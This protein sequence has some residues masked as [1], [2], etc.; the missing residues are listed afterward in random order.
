MSVNVNRNNPDPFYRYKMP[1]IVAKVEGK[2]NGIRTVI[3]NM[4]DVAKALA[5]PATYPTKFFGCKLGAQT[6]V[7]FKND[8]YIVNGAHEASKLQDLLDGFIKKYVLCPSCDNPETVLLVKSSI[9]NQTCK[10]CSH[11]GAI[12][13]D[14]GIN[15]Y[16]IKN[17][18]EVNP[19]SQGKSL[20]EGKRGRRSK[21]QQ[22]DSDD[23]NGRSSPPEGD[24][25][26]ID[27]EDDVG[28]DYWDSIAEEP[29]VLKEEL[30]ETLRNLTMN[31]DCELSE[32]E[33]M[34][35]F[36]E[37]V[38]KFRDAGTLGTKHKEL[39]SMA[40]RLEIRAKVPLILVELLCDEN[41]LSQAGKHRLLFRRFTDDNPKAQKYVIGGLEQIIALHK[42]VL[43][44]KVAHILKLFYDNDI[45][46]EK[47]I[48]E[49]AAK[50]SKKYVS[51]EL[52]EEMHQ[53]AEVFV[54]WLREAEEE[55]SESEEEDE[56][57]DDDV[58]I[59]YND[60]VSSTQLTKVQQPPA[61]KP[62]AAE[63]GIDDIDIDAI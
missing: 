45:L 59:E 13:V 8:R 36:Y 21:R 54:K 17:P 38:K 58:E 60:R 3:V 23:K 34:D 40:D 20:T 53:K 5:R 55:E 14:Y 57:D 1:R 29:S 12:K 7:D 9:I 46:D 31:E 16:I 50:V 25:S 35:L 2:G 28:D 24:E 11:Y 10:A 37:E 51:K 15:T 32:K 18:P 62:A 4:S 44:P 39:E 30:T 26:F 48:L 49:W 33:R 47:V 41:L 56:D 22:D 61:K 27:D 6:Q 19:A 42:N 63:D 43:M 52:S